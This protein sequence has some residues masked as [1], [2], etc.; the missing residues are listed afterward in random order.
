MSNKGDD[1]IKEQIL[2]YAYML[3]HEL[4][5]EFKNMYP[6]VKLPLNEERTERPTIDVSDHGK[7]PGIAFNTNSGRGSFFKAEPGFRPKL[8]VPIGKKIVSFIDI[9]GKIKYKYE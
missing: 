5:T 6:D 3:E 1:K 4:V 8:K 7:R 2:G 9:D